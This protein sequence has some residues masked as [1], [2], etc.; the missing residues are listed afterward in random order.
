[1]YINSCKILVFQTITAGVILNCKALHLMSKLS[2]MTKVKEKV[3][4]IL[5]FHCPMPNE[6]NCNFVIQ[7]IELLKGFQ[8]LKTFF[9]LSGSLISYLDKKYPDF[10]GQIRNLLEQNKLELLSGGM[11]EPILPFIPKEDRQAQ[12]SL[13]NMFINHTYGYIPYGAW[14]TEYSW[15]PVF[16]D[17]LIL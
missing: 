15:E 4:L 11:Y 7:L 13:M 1:M 17:S 5:G 8:N 2:Y 12:I 9:H 16:W 14:I 10:S 6:S 3:N